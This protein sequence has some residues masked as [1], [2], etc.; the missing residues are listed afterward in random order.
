ME[1]G[2]KKLPRN[3]CAVSPIV[4]TLVMIIIS[5]VAGVMIFGW[6]S[7][8]ISTGIPTGPTIINL[9]IQALPSGYPPLGDTWEITI[10]GL[11]GTR[12]VPIKNATVVMNYG[13]GTIEKTTD[14]NGFVDFKRL[15]KY[16]KNVTFEASKGGYDNVTYI[17]AKWIPETVE[18]IDTNTANLWQLGFVPIGLLFSIYLGIRSKWKSEGG[19]TYPELIIMICI[20][21]SSVISFILYW[22][23]L[24]R[25][26]YTSNKY[27]YPEN[28]IS[29]GM[30]NI[31]FNGLFT[32]HLFTIILCLLLFLLLI[33]SKYIPT[34]LK[35]VSSY[36]C[37]NNYIKNSNYLMSY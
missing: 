32:W 37:D 23:W 34:K 25:H 22:N 8:F 4:A 2:I 13:N 29:F 9:E 18:F 36:P 26:I 11:N 14:I 20:I 12:G 27:G 15:Q 24:Q 16:G 3:R 19:F 28:V 33:L 31:T 17:S 1:V 30:F 7:G 10:I 35:T 6:V 21:L 5:V